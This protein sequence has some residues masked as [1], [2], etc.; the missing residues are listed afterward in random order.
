MMHIPLPLLNGLMTKSEFEPNF[1]RV[2]LLQGENGSYTMFR[3]VRKRVFGLFE[4]QC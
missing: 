1:L 2:D 3:K 4:E